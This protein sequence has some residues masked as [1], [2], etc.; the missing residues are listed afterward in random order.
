MKFAEYVQ[1]LQRTLNGAPD[2]AHWK[3]ERAPVPVFDR[4]KREVSFSAELE[5]L[6]SHATDGEVTPS[7]PEEYRAM[8]DGLHLYSRPAD[9]GFD[10]FYLSGIR[11]IPLKIRFI[12]GWWDIMT[13]NPESH[14]LWASKIASEKTAEFIRSQLRMG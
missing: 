1:T 12:N 6:D 13:D 11:M 9:G 5:F 10:V 3:M 14:L 4:D 8:L 7:T 2:A